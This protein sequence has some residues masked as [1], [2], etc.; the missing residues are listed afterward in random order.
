MK[1]TTIF[2]STRPTRHR[3]SSA[4][5]RGSLLI[6]AMLL[7]VIIGISLASFIQLGR[8]GLNISNRSFYNNAG[9]NLAETG[10]E[11]AMW[12]VNKQSTDSASAWSSWTL[13]GVNS[14]RKW[15][16]F[17]FD[18]NTTGLVRVYINNYNGGAGNPKLVA[19][20]TITP[21]QGS[22]IEKWIEVTLRKRSKF[23][24]GLVAKQSIS[25][26]GNNATVD[27]WNSDP[28]NNPATA[29]VPYSSA[30]KHDNG[31]VGS[32]SVSVDAVLVQNAD[33]WGFAATGGALPSVGSNG[34]VGPFGTANG[35][36][37]PS[38]VSTDFSANF[39]PVTPPSA[40]YTALGNINSGMTLPRAG[41]VAAADGKYYYSAGQVNFNNAALVISNKVVL[42]LTNSSSSIDIGGG[43]G[44]LNINTGATLEVYAA[45]DIKIAGNGVL[46]GGTT[47]ASANQPANLQIWG[48]KTS[49]TQDIQIAGN[50]VLSAVV[51]APMGSVKINGNGDVEGSVVAN[52]ITVVGNAQFHYDE[53]L[54][55]LG[56]NNPY[57]ITKWKELTL[58]ADRAAYASV[59]SF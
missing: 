31:S 36:M 59:L 17:A 43:S 58:A 27:S 51:Y 13:A 48:T 45:G 57:G 29:A 56:G 37:D 12:S 2:L 11:E 8:T 54:G 39:D 41:D 3:L 55:N 6:V 53:S 14:S 30:V 47:L 33:I 42:Q 22:P 9:I 5:S 40:S 16:G 23:A 52:D 4:G 50:G 35:T 7:C 49:S 44:A 20:A 19:R 34:R 10:L 24:N 32:I 28:D 25:F 18:Q 38:R 15:T 26:S 21:P 1:P 46:N